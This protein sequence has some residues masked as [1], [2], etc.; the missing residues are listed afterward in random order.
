MPQ[1][2]PT[3][4][5]RDSRAQNNEAPATVQPV[6]RAKT[7]QTKRIVHLARHAVCA[8]VLHPAWHAVVATACAAAL[9]L[10]GGHHGF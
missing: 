10:L 4:S 3:D 2:K 1:I 9:V 7:N 8:I 6:T 5:G